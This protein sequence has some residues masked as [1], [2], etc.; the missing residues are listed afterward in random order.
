MLD[1]QQITAAVEGVDF[2]ATRDEVVE[3]ATSNGAPLE[4]VEQL[5]GAEQDRYE[6]LADLQQAVRRIEVAEAQAGPER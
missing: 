4:V 2:P 1:P 5:R 3:R 6:D